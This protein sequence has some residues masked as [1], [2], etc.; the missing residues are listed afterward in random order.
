MKRSW[1]L[2]KLPQGKKVMT[3]KWIF[4]R[5]TEIP[6]YENGMCV[7]AYIYKLCLVARG[8][9]QE[10]GVEY[11]KVFSLVVHH[12]SISFVG[13]CGTNAFGIGAI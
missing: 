1:E 10:Q 12:T 5:K 4:K 3:F 2:V 11:K 6:R 7:Y 9:I 8:H 13:S